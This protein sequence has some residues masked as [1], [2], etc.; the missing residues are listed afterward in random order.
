VSFDGGPLKPTALR[1]T[2]IYRRENGDWKLVH[3]H[4]DYLPA[5]QNPPAQASTA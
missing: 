4:G 2:H 5:N 1:V 3:R